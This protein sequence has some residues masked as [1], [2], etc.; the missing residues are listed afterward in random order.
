[1]REITRREAL[2]IGTA[3]T[4]S[5]VPAPILVIEEGRNPAFRDYPVAADPASPMKL[6]WRRQYLKHQLEAEA[7]GDWERADQTNA[8]LSGAHGTLE[9]VFCGPPPAIRRDFLARKEAA[10]Q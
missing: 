7:R 1:M 2:C 10:F 8:W 3:A 9:E 5:L 6:K 4:V